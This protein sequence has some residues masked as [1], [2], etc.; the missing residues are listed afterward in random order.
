MPEHRGPS[1]AGRHRSRRR[2]AR[3]RVRCSASRP[4]QVVPVQDRERPGDV[5]PAAISPAGGPAA[6]SGRPPRARRRRAC[7]RG[8]R[9][10]RR[11]PRRGPW[12]AARE[13]DVRPQR[14]HDR[15]QRVRVGTAEHAA[16]QH[17]RARC[18]PAT[19]DSCAAR[20]RRT[21]SDRGQR[22]DPAVLRRAA[23][24]ARARSRP[25]WSSARPSGPSRSASTGS[26]TPS[27]CAL[28]QHPGRRRAHAEVALDGQQRPV[29][30]DRAVHVRGR[31]AD[32][33]D[34]HPHAEH[35]GE[36]RRGPGHHAPAC[37]PAP[38]AGTAAPT[39][40]PRPPSDVVA[41]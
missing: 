16:G 30:R 15:R 36:Q 1:V 23:R 12:P 4:G 34:Q 9:R 27:A 24:V 31:A 21:A 17:E 40:G 33:D 26:T 28:H 22:R 25:R 2:R 41:A 20:C 10:S 14:R 29:V 3:S 38:A 5:K 6:A 39:D 37:R 11:P 19:S 13:L 35:P 18:H 7:P 32:V 8:R